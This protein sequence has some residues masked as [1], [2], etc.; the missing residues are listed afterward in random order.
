MTPATV[1]HDLTGARQGALSGLRELQQFAYQGFDAALVHVG[2]FQ[3][4]LVDGFIP[5]SV[6]GQGFANLLQGSKNV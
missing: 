2:S 6:K 3:V 1:Y 4:C 5:I